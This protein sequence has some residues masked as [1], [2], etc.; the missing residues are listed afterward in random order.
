MVYN[1]W[2][3][4]DGCE[5]RTSRFQIEDDRTI[6]EVSQAC[7]SL[8]ISCPICG[9]KIKVLGMMTGVI[10]SKMSPEKIKSHF[11]KRS[12]EHYKE[13]IQPEEAKLNKQEIGGLFKNGQ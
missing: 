3:F 4:T 7:E 8:E 6:N 13:A 1:M 2:C 12:H 11:K 5:N 10:I 9:G